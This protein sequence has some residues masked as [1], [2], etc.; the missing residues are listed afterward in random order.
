MT[1]R[2]LPVRFADIEDAARRAG[3][4]V[5]E[6]PLIATPALSRRLGLD[7]RLKLENLQITQS[8]KAR[9]AFNKLSRLSAEERARGVI[10]LSAGNHA[11]GVAWH[12]E[13][14]GIPATIVMPRHTPFTKVS[15]TEALGA[16]VE[17]VGDTLNDANDFVARLI[18]ER[19]LTLVHPYDDP[20]IIAGQG[21]V[22]LEMAR[23]CDCLDCV[24]VPIGG[25]GLIA[26]TAIA[27]R[28]AWPE[29]EIVGVQSALF[30]AMR[31]ALAGRPGQYQGATLAEGIAVKSPGKITREIIAELVDD[32]LI[33]DED[34]I[35]GA[36]HLLA[37]EQKLVI[38]G[39]GAAGLAAIQAFTDRFAGRRVGTVLC[40][41]NI[42]PRVLSSILMRGL[43]RAGQLVCLLIEIDDSPGNLA[44][45]SGVI[46]EA[47]GNIVE[48][49]HR[50][51]MLDL[52]VKRIDLEVII[53]SKDSRHVERIVK[54]LEQ[55]GYSA[56]IQ[57]TIG[58]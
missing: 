24:V 26:G 53:E 41:G 28:Q 40:G 16:N 12:A 21:T 10:A 43:A 46:G 8:F 56:Q 5:V 18:E 2:D 9:G 30:P 3:D 36:I 17:L 34:M 29:V 49:Q 7:L 47:G 31:D 37:T 42:D 48:V 57:T 19:G 51:L 39:A 13:A 22:G 14:L 54:A 6:T 11:Q 32:I 44:R 25:G 27:L 35:E 23:Q 58:T 45:V 15:R 4:N 20:L 38:E 55:H 1:A 33:V 52:P 50:R